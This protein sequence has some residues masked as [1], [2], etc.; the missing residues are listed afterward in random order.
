MS[1]DSDD[2]E[3]AAPQPAWARFNESGETLVKQRLFGCS[4]QSCL[5][6]A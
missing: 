4:V 6:C 2:G 1:T 3:Q 5:R